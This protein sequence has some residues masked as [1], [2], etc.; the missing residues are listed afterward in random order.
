[1]ATE[2][3]RIRPASFYVKGKKVGTTET[4]KYSIA[5]NDERH[6]AD[7][8]YIGHSDGASVSDITCNVIVPIDGKTAVLKRALLNKEYL[9]CQIGVV[10]GE[11]D[12]MVMRCTKADYDVDHKTGALKGAFTFE[13]GEPESVLADTSPHPHG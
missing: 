5:G 7:G 12:S 4:L 1:M 9:T 13:G 10:D 11:I 3:A 2:P 8:G 6:I